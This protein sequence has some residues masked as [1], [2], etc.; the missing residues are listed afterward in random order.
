[1]EPWGTL[2]MTSIR[3]GRETDHQA[4]LADASGRNSY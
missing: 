2:E 1:M 3:G 4:P